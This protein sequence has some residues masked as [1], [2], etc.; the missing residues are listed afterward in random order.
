MK[1]FLIFTVLFSLG[2]SVF[3]QEY[4]YWYR[5]KKQPLE[6]DPTR[7][8]ISV[9]STDDTLALK[10]KLIEQ[11][12]HLPYFMVYRSC[13]PANYICGAIIKG[14]NLPN[15]TEDESVIYEGPYFKGG[16]GAWNEGWDI[17]GLNEEFFVRLKNPGD[18]PALENLAKENNVTLWGAEDYSA[19]SGDPKF[20]Y[21]ILTC[22]KLSN[23]NAMQMA[24]LFYE[25]G[26]C[27]VANIGVVDYGTDATIGGTDY[28]GD[29]PGSS[30]GI[31]LP[32]TKPAV[33]LYREFGSSIVIEAEGDRIKEVEIFDLSGKILH[34]SSYS[35]VA[36]TNW[37]A[38]QKGLYL[39]KIRLQSGNTAYKKIII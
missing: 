6:L 24:N 29:D 37:K 16:K 39:V 38:D 18:L 11:N 15:F 1:R 30:T 20:S 26:L 8:Y 4:Y 2:I 34:K 23:G 35:G 19:G 5:G 27:D 12:I 33:N 13:W 31:A 10:N 7:K 3:A 36:Q 32:A 22:S 9:R 21:Y 28:L 17:G 25:S 14:N